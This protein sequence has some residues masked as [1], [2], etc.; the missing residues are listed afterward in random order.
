MK[1]ALAAAFTAGLLV[2]LSGC[3]KVDDSTVAPGVKVIEFSPEKDQNVHCVFAR[4]GLV[5]GLSCFPVVH[6]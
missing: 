1:I 3:D 6:P 4:S 5:G 2:V